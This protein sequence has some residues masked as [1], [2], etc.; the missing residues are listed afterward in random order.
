MKTKSVRR[1]INEYA[2]FILFENVGPAGDG[3]GG[4][5]PCQHWNQNLSLAEITS[6]IFTISQL[7]IS[8]QLVIRIEK[9]FSVT[10]DRRR[11]VYGIYKECHEE[12][13]P[14]VLT[15]TYQKFHKLLLKY[16]CEL[17]LGDTSMSTSIYRCYWNIDNIDVFWRKHRCFST[18]F[19]YLFIF[20]CMY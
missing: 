8:N 17:V 9:H 19:I 12:Q 2:F 10:S 11:V 4:K 15:I 16:L 14:K 18:F 20:F 5:R 13:H 7:A 1:L 6:N 3:K